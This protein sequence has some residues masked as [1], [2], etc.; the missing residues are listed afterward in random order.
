[1]AQELAFTNTRQKR[2]DEEY[3]IGPYGR[4]NPNNVVVLDDKSY[5]ISGRFGG[6][7][8]LSKGDN[9]QWS[10]LSLDEE[11]DGPLLF[12]DLYASASL[13]E[14]IRLR[15]KATQSHPSHPRFKS[16]GPADGGRLSVL[17]ECR[18]NPPVP[19]F[20]DPYRV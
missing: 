18:R 15:P 17:W 5:F 10:F 6:I 12:S 19:I 14:V 2:F 1:L 20:D 11:R 3:T 4:W 16:E 8:L 9:G 7:Y 13:R